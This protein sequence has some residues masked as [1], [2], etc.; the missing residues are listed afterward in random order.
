MAADALGRRGLQ[1]RNLQN[2]RAN[3]AHTGKTLT[4]SVGAVYNRATCETY[5]RTTRTH[6][7]FW[8]LRKPYEIFAHFCEIS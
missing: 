2:L 7:E 6:R 8:Y 3:N 4:H 5:A 1:P